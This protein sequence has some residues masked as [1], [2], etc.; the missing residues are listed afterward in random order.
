[1][2][3]HLLDTTLLATALRDCGYGPFFAAYEAVLRVLAVPG[4]TAARAGKWQVLVAGG[5]AG[6]VG[7]V[8]TFPMDVVK[9]LIQAVPV[10]TVTFGVFEAGH[11][12]FASLPL[13]TMHPAIHE[14]LPTVEFVAGTLGGMAGLAAGFPFDTVKVRL[15]KPELAGRYR[16]STARAIAKIVQEERVAGLFKGISSP[17]AAAGLLNGAVFSAYA[18]LLDIQV[19]GTGGTDPARASL[20]QVALAGAGSGIG[21]TLITTPTELVKIRQQQCTGPRAA[22][23]GAVVADLVRGVGVR[24][25]FRGALATALR[26]C[27]YG[28]YFVAYEA[29]ARALAGPESGGAHKT[30]W[31]VLVAVGWLA[32]FPLDVVKTRVQGSSPTPANPYRTTWSTIVYSY[33]NEGLRVF[34]RGLAPTLIRAVPVNMVTFGVFEAVVGVAGRDRGGRVREQGRG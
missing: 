3:S 22:A 6:V 16:G 23:A 24:G 12:N 2:G 29:T 33:R 10:Y 25:L 31:Q 27:G 21:A 11:G 30:K 14:F 32:T 13:F 26:D 19:L 28:A 7:W 8:V 17:L 9:T 34:Y 18:L 5:V 20:A 4:S 1:M 15:Q